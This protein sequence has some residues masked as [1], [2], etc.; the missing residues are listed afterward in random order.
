MSKSILLVY[1]FVSK[2]IRCF[3]LINF[4][5]SLTGSPQEQVSITHN[6]NNPLLLVTHTWTS[7]TIIDSHS[8]HVDAFGH[9]TMDCVRLETLVHARVHSVHCVR[10]VEGAV[11]GVAERM[12]FIW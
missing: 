10:G 5:C 3:F 7:H 2:Y 6:L 11:V 9:V 12:M 8:V 4:I 1:F